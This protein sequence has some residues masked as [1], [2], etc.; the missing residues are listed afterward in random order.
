[1]YVCTVA[2]IAMLLCIFLRKIEMMLWTIHRSTN[3]AMLLFI[4]H[5]K[6]AMLLWTIHRST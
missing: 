5:S 4:F 3:I 2:K 6:I 1:M